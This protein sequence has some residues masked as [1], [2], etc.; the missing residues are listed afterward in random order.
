MR[1]GQSAMAGGLGIFVRE[2][3]DADT[4]NG[5][6]RRTYGKRTMYAR[7]GRAG[8]RPI[9]FYNVHGYHNVAKKRK[10]MDGITDHLAVLGGDKVIIGDFNEEP[11][12]R[13][14]TPYLACGVYHNTDEEI[15][16]LEP[17]RNGEDARHIDLTL[18]SDGVKILSQETVKLSFSDDLMVIY[19]MELEEEPARRKWKKPFGARAGL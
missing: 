14:I 5:P 3:V 8:G 1:K 19:D 6:K 15:D 2:G 13:V 4:I 18:H 11:Y 7:F 10:L 17:T 16:Q 12:S 9:R